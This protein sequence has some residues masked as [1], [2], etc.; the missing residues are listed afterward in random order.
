MFF[1][2]LGM[3]L[4]PQGCYQ[5]QLII[6]ADINQYGKNILKIN[7]SFGFVDFTDKII[8]YTIGADSIISFSPNISFSEYTSMSIDGKE[9]IH[10]QVNELGDVGINHPYQIITRREGEVDTF[11][12][13]FT[14]IPLLHIVTDEEIRNDPK[15]LSRI[16]VQYNS[17]DDDSR[18]TRTINSI[19]GVEIRGQSSTRYDKKSFGLE[20]WKNEFE[21]DYSASL[22]GMHYGEDW[23][24]DAMYI[25]D[26]RMRNKISFELWEK[27]S[28]VPLEDQKPEVVPGIHCEYVEVFLNNRYHGLYT[29]N[30]KLDENILHYSPSQ[31]DLGGVLYK[32]EGWG[33][34]STRFDSCNSSPP[35]D[36]FW[37][38]WIQ[39][40]P[41]TSIAWGPLDDLRQLI[42]HS[43]DEVFRNEIEYMFDLDNA[44]DYYF[45][46]NLIMGL[47]NTGKN[48]YLARYTDQSTFFYMPWDIEATWGLFWTREKIGYSAIVTNNL[49]RRLIET[50]AGGY[51][52]RL[53]EKWFELRNGIFSEEELLQAADEYYELLNK[54]GV[55]DRE[56]FRWGE[57]IID[58]E[59][60]HDFIIEW[61]GNR[62][63]YLDDYFE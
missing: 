3:I 56:N 41:K 22:L 32:A 35:D 63:E 12:L 2:F 15:V 23:I 60:E 61:I 53:K 38:D 59:S 1:V 4:I 50:N 6:D 14:R 16:S 48:T 37:D 8:L 30:E 49:F 43:N 24:L 36:Y 21:D 46:I 33:N 19:A 34:G 42:V 51:N 28:S 55:I 39:L 17:K 18:S 7:Q 40:Y 5:E 54:S 9:L 57:F 11:Q 29:L 44:I 26:L 62:L 58:L 31:D 27:L 47:D 13:I 45:F 20:L 10:N 25:D 52:M